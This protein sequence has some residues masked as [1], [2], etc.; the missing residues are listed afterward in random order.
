[1]TG[2]LDHYP[3]LQTASVTRTPEQS[4]A[5][6]MTNEGGPPAEVGTEGSTPHEAAEAPTWIRGK[7]RAKLRELG[8]RYLSLLFARYRSA[9]ES[10]GAVPERMHRVAKQTR[11]MLEA[12]DDFKAGAYREIP[13][14]SV[15]VMAG[16]LLYT[17]NPADVVPDIVPFLGTLDDITLVAVAVRLVQKDLRRYC[18][19]KGY[20][21][22]EYF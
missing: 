10:M 4:Q 18:E 11:L 21:P 3:P 13:W 12:L 17:L 22:D 8:T 19:Y 16:A 6:A 20:S 14:S 1:M 15:V 7:A 9:S 2:N 5:E